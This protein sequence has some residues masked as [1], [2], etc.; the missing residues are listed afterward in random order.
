VED[1]VA[2]K[3]LAQGVDHVRHAFYLVAVVAYAKTAL[4]K[5]MKPFVKLMDVSRSV[6]E[7]MSLDS[8][9][10]LLSHLKGFADDILQLKGEGAKHPCQHDPVVVVPVRGVIDLVGEDVIVEGVVT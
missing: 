9:P 1:E 4:P 8:K 2:M 5:S 3:Q 7:E 6:D 10:R